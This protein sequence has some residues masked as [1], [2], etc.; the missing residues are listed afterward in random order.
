MP[1][2]S[3][4]AIANNYEIR[5]TARS[6]E[7]YTKMN[8]HVCIV[9]VVYPLCTILLCLRLSP[10]LYALLPCFTSAIFVLFLFLSLSIWFSSVN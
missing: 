1:P 3:M 10:P 9:N 5:C 6:H 8:V 7:I 2:L 4:T